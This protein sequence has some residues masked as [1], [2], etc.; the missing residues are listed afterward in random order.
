MVKSVGSVPPAGAAVTFAVGA[1]TLG[2][3]YTIVFRA[4]LSNEG[5]STRTIELCNNA[6]SY[7]I[8]A[9]L[10]P[11]VWYPLVGAAL[12]KAAPLT[13]IGFAWPLLMM[14][15]DLLWTTK[16]PLDPDDTK[17]TTFT[18][19][20]NAISS[21]SFALGGLLLSQIGKVFAKSAA[22]MLSASIF[23]VIAFVIPSPGVTVRSGLGA[24]F[25]SSK[26]IAMAFCVGL[27][28]SAIAITLQVGLKHRSTITHSELR[29]M[30]PLESRA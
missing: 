22:P 9:F 2:I 29:T 16:Q 18:F 27:L 11:M 6:T 7:A 26:K 20:G 1:L 14:S 21:L 5:V 25:L 30:P 10:W 17:R 15:V 3:I 23:L 19:D 28:I 12:V 4:R 8:G 24:V 13:L